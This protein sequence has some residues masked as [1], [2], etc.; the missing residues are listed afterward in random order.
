MNS[1][2]PA[3]LRIAVPT[4]LRQSFDY[5]MPLAS[6]DHAL[7]PGIRVRVPFQHR[8]LVGI[9]LETLSESTVPHRKLKQ[10]IEIIDE[11]PVIPQ[12]VLQLC[13]WASDYYHHP[14]G[15]V[16]DTALPVLLRQGKPAALAP[17][18]YWQLTESGLT[19]DPEKLKRAPKQLDLI[20]W[21]SLYPTGVTKRQL[22]EHKVV[23]SLLKALCE[24]GFIEKLTRAPLSTP[25]PLTNNVELETPLVLNSAQQQS[26]TAIL[27]ALEQFQV[28]LLD[29]VTGSGKTE[30]YLQAITAVL[31]QQKQVLVL[32]PEIGLTPKPFNVSGNVFLC[33]LLPCILVLAIKKD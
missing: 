2:K 7:Q 12:D 22:L 25:Q 19:L 4:P 30:V 3:I 31:A 21:F 24:K 23:G 13:L 5:L 17:E 32:V 33:R 26:L 6:E 9:L 28:F 20:K 14:V 10:V 16:L 8:E 18:T 1:K 15:D 27:S 29:G 11:L